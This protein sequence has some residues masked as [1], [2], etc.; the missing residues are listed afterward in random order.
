[1]EDESS[2][3]PLHINVLEPVAKLEGVS[4]CLVEVPRLRVGKGEKITLA[5]PLMHMNPH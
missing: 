1:M 3:T 5:M 2:F 4:K